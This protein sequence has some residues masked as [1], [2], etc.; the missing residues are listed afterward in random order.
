M[1]LDL[2][3]EL[4][5]LGWIA[6]TTWPDGDEDEMWAIA[7]A[8]K[9]ASEEL[10]ALLPDIDRAKLDTVRAY[11]QGAAADEMG[12]LFDGLRTGDQSLESL[13]QLLQQIS[14][15]AFDMGTQLQATK[16][17]IIVSLCWLAM[18]ILWAWLFPPTAPAVEAA[19]ITTTRSFLRVFEDT[20]Q[21]LITNLARKLGASAE[22]RYFWKTLAGGRFVLPTAKGWGVYGVKFAEGAVTSAGLNAAVQLGQMADGKRRHFDGREFGISILASAAGTLPSRE[23]ARYM[24]R[25][26][27]KWGAHA[28]NNVWGRTGR[29][30]FI[31]AGAGVV[32]SVAGN[33]AVGAATGDW[34]SFASPAGWVGSVTRGG[35]VGGARGAFAKS[36][37]ISRSDVRY[38]LWM[39]RPGAPR[40]P[41]SNAAS[42]GSGST[43]S[44]GRSSI[45]MQ[46]L[47]G[48]RGSSHGRSVVTNSQG[49]GGGSRGRGGDGS[50]V[51]TASHN[52]GEGSGSNHGSSSRGT[53]PAPSVVANGGSSHG[54]G[55]APSVVANGGSSRGT[56]P[57]PSV[58]ANGGS[59]RGTG[60]APSVVTNGSSSHGTGPAPS[61]VANGSSSRGTSPAPSIVENGGGSQHSST[62]PITANG[63]GSHQP[64]PAARSGDG[65][66][67]GRGDTGS[68]GTLASDGRSFH[69]G[70]GT[71]DSQGQS[72][73]TARESSF[74]TAQESHGSQSSVR[75]ST[76]DAGSSGSNRNGFVP[77]T[78]WQS[79]V[80]GGWRP[81]GGHGSVLTGGA[82]VAS[83]APG[84]TVSGSSVHGSSGGGSSHTP[85]QPPP[86][87]T[88]STRSGGGSSHAPSQPP[89]GDTGSTRSGG[90]SNTPGTQG[91]PAR[92]PAEPFLGPGKDM[93]A[94]T[95]PKLLPHW[96]PLPGAFD[97]PDAPESSVWVLEQSDEAGAPDE[98]TAHIGVDVPFT[99][100][101]R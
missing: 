100:N 15:S 86:G 97:A 32:S 40:T 51:H 11:P 70:R 59:S 83:P 56:G 61:A 14:D 71:L 96:A 13:A 95:R 49:G 1:S 21:K 75:G 44:P 79:S 90:S 16:L 22:K 27:D 53:S 2:P 64:V 62:A 24:G 65:T 66:P 12:K 23:F 9:T 4:R 58:V 67:T 48:D 39:H 46:S 38:P 98:G 43:R 93:K 20:V 8:W 78:S 88:G 41:P 84:S 54:T 69:T 55:P 81:P 82:P 87:D 85:S 29:G 28:L 94:K 68:H 26:I 42:Q 77:P 92:P 74:H 6:G 63:S 101:N 10:Q 33:L 91:N 19:A 35:L 30:V 3:Q 7:A 5:W 34:S 80:D 17:T 25:G 57:A 72:F 37:P 76:S 73:H 52:S 18:E 99:L 50:A 47:Q 89:P 31:G 60:P 36:T 45:E